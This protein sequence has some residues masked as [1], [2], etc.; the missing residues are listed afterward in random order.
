[1]NEDVLT[2]TFMSRTKS[3]RVTKRSLGSFVFQRKSRHGDAF[4]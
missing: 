1:M 2:S 3:L 4:Q